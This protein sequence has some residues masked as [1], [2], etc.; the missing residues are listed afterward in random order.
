MT[1]A[2]SR[3]DTTDR[4]PRASMSVIDFNGPGPWSYREIQRRYADYAAQKKV[5]SRNLT[6][7][8]HIDEHGQTWI[9]PLM[10]KVI[11][12]IETGDAACIALGVDFIEEEQQFTFGKTLK[13]NTARALRRAA[14]RSELDAYQK[15]RIRERVL[16]MLGR[17]HVPHEYREYAKLLRA[18][19]FE[20]RELSSVAHDLDRANPHV[21]R[22]YRYFRQVLKQE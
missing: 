8:S 5:E 15:Q 17:G 16:G 18:V 2:F 10:E 21:M 7:R 1:G 4:E 22:F 13:A 20:R 19:G 14:R 6:P 12:G 3:Q 11:E 9:Y